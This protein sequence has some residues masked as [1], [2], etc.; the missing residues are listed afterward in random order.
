MRMSCNGCRVLRKGCSESCSIR[1]CLQWIK[2]PQ[3]QANATFF[4]AK[5]YGRAGLLN[6]INAGPDHLRPAIFKSLLF[7]ACGR[8]VN[9]IFGSAGLLWS[10]SW[11]LC[12]DAV[13]A[14]LNGAPIPPVSYEMATSHMGPPSKG[15][16]IRHVSKQ[17]GSG[18]SEIKKR[19]RFKRKPKPKEEPVMLP[20]FVVDGSTRISSEP[21]C[22]KFELDNLEGHVSPE[23]V[24]G[25]NDTECLSVETTEASSVGQGG[26]VELELTLGFGHG[27]MLTCKER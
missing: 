22:F 21:R 14:V 1:P 9:P 13:E 15:C 27:R 25:S 19:R 23:K 20:Q 3:S 26:G 8:I 12:Q 18:L 2:T 7:E 4:L 6:L 17:Q 16:D 24:C 11:Q 5:F 10:G